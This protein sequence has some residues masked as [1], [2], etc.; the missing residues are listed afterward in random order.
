MPSRSSLREYHLLITRGN[1]GYSW[2]IRFN[3]HARAVQT[4]VSVH[5]SHD[6]AQ[7]AGN[8]AL[9]K[10]KADLLSHG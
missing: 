9:L 6:G 2:E 5:A 3:R 7:E 1:G 10:L 8:K 4:S